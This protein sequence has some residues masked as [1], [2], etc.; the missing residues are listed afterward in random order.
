MVLG[1]IAPK[2]I[3]VWEV[4][5][6]LRSGLEGPKRIE[7]IY[8]PVLKVLVVDS[9]LYRSIGVRCWDRRPV[10]PLSAFKRFM[11]MVVWAFL[12]FR[13]WVPGQFCELAS[14]FRAAALPRLRELGRNR[15]DSYSRKDGSWLKLLSRF[16]LSA[17]SFSSN[18]EMFREFAG[19]PTP[20]SAR[21]TD[22]PQPRPNDVFY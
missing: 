3:S 20:S 13:L 2:R 22:G 1:V 15:D 7:P 19:N 4:P 12:F 14:L 6:R 11:C 18:N 16:S 21:V 5:W 17:A 8:T 9:A 10:R